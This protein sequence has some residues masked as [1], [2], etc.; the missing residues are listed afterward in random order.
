M[1]VTQINTGQFLPGTN[2]TGTNIILANT[3]VAQLTARNT[4]NA[5]TTASGVNGSVFISVADP[6][7]I[8]ATQFVTGTGISSNTFVN[9]INGSVVELTNTITSNL[10]ASSVSFYTPGQLGTYT[11]TPGG[12][13]ANGTVNASATQG[14]GAPNGFAQTGGGGGGGGGN[15]G[16]GGTGGS[17]IVIISYPT[18]FTQPTTTGSPTVTIYGTNTVYTFTGAGSIKWV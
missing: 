5:T 2:V 13:A 17:G 12:V 3:V 14:V 7:N 10:S 6:T 1:N 9:N 16:D 8:Y 11:V 15:G 4:A 18:S